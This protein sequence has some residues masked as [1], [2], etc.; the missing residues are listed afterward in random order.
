M[1]IAN[2]LLDARVMSLDYGGWDSHGDQRIVPAGL[3]NDPNNPDFSRGIENGLRDIFGGQF[4]NSPTD[5]SAL[6]GGF[7]ALWE[8]LSQADRSKIVVTIAGEFGRQ[9]RD[10]GAFGTDHG[11]GN[12]IFLI[13]EK[14]NGGLYGDLFPESEVDKLDDTSVRAP[15][16]T[17]ET[18]IDH[19]FGAACDW[20]VGGNST[21]FPNRSNADLEANVSFN[22][23]FTS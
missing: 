21:V 10:N 18:D 11:E 20:V 12:Y 6:H 7:S 16:I 4:G 5:S 1:I 14:I 2:D 3:A 17:P 9:I 22:S 23:L 13:S 8:S 15:A 19:I